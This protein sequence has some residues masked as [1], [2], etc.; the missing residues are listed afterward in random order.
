MNWQFYHLYTV[1]YDECNS[2]GVLTPTAFL[3]YMQDVAALDAEDAQLG[4][5]GYWIVKHTNIVFT[6]PV[7]VHTRLKLK[8]FG[9][10]YTRITVQRGYEAYLAD[11]DGEPIISAKTLWVYV[12]AHGRPTRLPG[13]TAHIW[14]PDGPLPQQQEP[15]F[16]VT[17]QTSPETTSLMVRYSDIDLMRHLNNASAVEMLDD[18]SWHVYAQSGVLPGTA[19]FDVLSYEIEYV[20]SPRFGQQLEIQSWLDP[21]PSI[22]QD[23][24]RFQ[25]ITCEGK[26]MVKAS[27]RWR[28]R[29]KNSQ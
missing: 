27:S 5:S 17:P 16:P 26:V 20:D 11:E 24:S 10:N 7:P 22:G 1:R 21:L 15:P 9:M 29:T 25:Q 14:L 28:Y 13:E 3:R 23:H 12:D 18:A 19:A 4:G 2:D 8:T 6:T